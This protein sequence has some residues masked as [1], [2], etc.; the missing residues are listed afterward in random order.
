MRG[1]LVSEWLRL[2]KWWGLWIGLA[3]N[4]GVLGWR[5]WTQYS[6]MVAHLTLAAGGRVDALW[7]ASALF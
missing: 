4:W 6:G 3:A 5:L 7:S 2:R 1:I